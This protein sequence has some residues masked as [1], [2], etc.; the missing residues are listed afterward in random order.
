MAV[1]VFASQ[2]KA[3]VTTYEKG[4]QVRYKDGHLEVLGKLGANSTKTLAI[5]S[6]GNWH[7]ADVDDKAA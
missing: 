4:T 7:H 6:P 3:S 2:Q 1:K 5:Y